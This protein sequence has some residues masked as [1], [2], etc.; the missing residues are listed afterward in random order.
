MSHKF[1][2]DQAVVLHRRAAGLTSASWV[3]PAPSSRPVT[4]DCLNLDAFGV[5]VMN[6]S[7]FRQLCEAGLVSSMLVAPLARAVGR[8]WRDEMSSAG[9]GRRSRPAW[10]VRML[11]SGSV[12]RKLSEHDGSGR[13][14]ACHQRCLDDRLNRFLGDIFRWR[15][16]KRSRTCERRAAPCKRPLAG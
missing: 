4:L 2:L 5:S 16:A 1:N 15:S 13:Q 6:S 9:S 8:R 7:Y 11:R 12:C 10:Q 14:A 3:R